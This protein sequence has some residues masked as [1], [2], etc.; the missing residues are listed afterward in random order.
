MFEGL[1][2]MGKEKEISMFAIIYKYFTL[3]AHYFVL[4]DLSFFLSFFLS[5]EKKCKRNPPPQKTLND[6]KGT[7]RKEDGMVSR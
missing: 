3:S 2:M 5:F 4:D 6:N 1:V 7:G